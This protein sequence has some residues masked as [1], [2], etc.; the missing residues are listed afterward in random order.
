VS[1]FRQV[2]AAKGLYL[3]HLL[4]L[5]PAVVVQLHRTGAVTGITGYI[6]HTY[7]YYWPNRI[8]STGPKT[9]VHPGAI[10]SAPRQS[11]RPTTAD[12]LSDVDNLLA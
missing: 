11:A 12:S 7:G 1:L 4:Y 3:H 10:S 6:L 2:V 5:F 8:R 9:V